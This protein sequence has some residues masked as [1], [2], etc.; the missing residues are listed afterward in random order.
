MTNKIEHQRHNWVRRILTGTLFTVGGLLVIGVIFGTVL[1]MGAFAQFAQYKLQIHHFVETIFYSCIGLV[2]LVLAFERALDLNKIDSTLDNQNK[3]L[4]KQTNLMEEQSK[5]FASIN[6]KLGDI[7]HLTD[8]IHT[9]TDIIGQMKNVREK[10]FDKFL[11]QIFDDFIDDTIEFFENAIKNGKI[12]FSEYDRFEKAYAKCLELKSDC[13]FFATAS[14][15]SNYFWTTEEE[16][17]N[18]IE[19]AII[20]FTKCGG[21]MNRIFLMDENELQDPRCIAT[22]NNQL[23][24]GVTVY[25]IN[26]NSL[27]TDN[28]KYFVVESSRQI[29]WHVFTD[30]DKKI[31]KFIYSTNER[32]VNKY[33]SIYETMMK[34]RTIKKYVRQ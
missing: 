16:E 24:I 2:C 9:Q 12:K 22:L 28:Q 6:S 29:S 27:S 21:K 20:E 33:H 1:D 23:K 18:S 10:H 3:V 34:N 4:E 14:T 13:E 8:K 11:N 17:N 7:H 31:S 32:D 15:H 19:E 5:N 30:N 26:K 25:T